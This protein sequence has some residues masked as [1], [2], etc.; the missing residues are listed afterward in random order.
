MDWQDLAIV[1]FIYAPYSKNPCSFN[2]C[3]SCEKC[4]MLRFFLTVD[5]YKGNE[6]ILN[7]TY[8]YI[9]ASLEM[10]IMEKTAE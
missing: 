5:I 7:Y 6:N 3:F 4:F 9:M 10:K 8:M 2:V 1:P